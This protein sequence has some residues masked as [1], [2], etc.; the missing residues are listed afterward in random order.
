MLAVARRNVIASGVSGVEL[1]QGNML[2]LPYGAEFDAVI[3]VLGLFFVDDM[4]AAARALWSHVRPGGRLAIA[5]FGTEVW[6]PVLSRFIATTARV[7]PDIERVLPW[8]RAEDPDVVTALLRAAGVPDARVERDI[9]DV[10]FRP[11][12]W[13]LIVMGSGLR[14]IA[15]DLGPARDEVLTDTVQWSQQRGLT[16]VRFSSNYAMARKRLDPAACARAE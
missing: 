9:D 6:E 13:P 14:R 3:C 8:R 7:R 4:A 16:T 10:S 11:E 5:T 1:A 2:A 12:D 15:D